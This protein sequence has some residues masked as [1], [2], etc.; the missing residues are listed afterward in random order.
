MPPYR[1]MFSETF[2]KRV[3]DLPPSPAARSRPTSDPAVPL[4]APSPLNPSLLLLVKQG[5]KNAELL[6]AGEGA[7]RGQELAP[8]RRGTPARTRYYRIRFESRENIL[9]PGRREG[10]LQRNLLK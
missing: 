6:P 1:A 4:V 5:V 7:P 8:A 10:A 9:R 2:L 3:K